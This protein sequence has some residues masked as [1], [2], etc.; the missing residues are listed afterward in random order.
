MEAMLFTALELCIKR[1][2]DWNKDYNVLKML[3]EKQ[4]TI[5]YC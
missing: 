3:L 5:N 4:L 2:S 1:I